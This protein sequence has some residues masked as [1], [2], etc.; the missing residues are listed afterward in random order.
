MSKRTFQVNRRITIEG[1][2][3]PHTQPTPEFQE[4]PSAVREFIIGSIVILCF[5]VFL[6]LIANFG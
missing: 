5:V 2:K 1:E 3:S 6:S 4:R